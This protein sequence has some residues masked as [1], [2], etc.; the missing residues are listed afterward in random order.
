MAGLVAIRAREATV[1]LD[2]VGRRIVM[3]RPL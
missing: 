2:G 3:Q 1:G